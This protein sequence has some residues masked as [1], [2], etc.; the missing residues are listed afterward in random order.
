MLDGA[1]TSPK[2]RRLAVILGVPWPHA[3][4]LAGL[5]WRFTAKHAPT[6]EIGRHDDEE[7]AAAL[8]WPGEA[9]DLVAALV[10]CRLLDPTESAARL[11]VHDWP[12]HAPRYVSATL[13]RQK[14][15]FSAEYR[16]STTVAT[17][18]P[19]VVPTTVETTYTS[20]SSSTSSGCA[21]AAPRTIQEG[22]HTKQSARALVSIQSHE[23]A[24]QGV[25]RVSMDE[26][27]SGPENAG[28]GI[29]RPL[30]TSLE[31]LAE[32]VWEAYLAGRKSGKRSALPIISKSIKARAKRDRCT[33]EEAADR[34][35]HAVEA[36]VRRM[37]ERIRTGETELKYCP[38][39]LTYF[40]Q[41][42][43]NDDDNGPTDHDV[44]EARIDDEIRRARAELG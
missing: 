27:S 3:L 23:D 40:R 5:L 4:G 35:R 29:L 6:G 34:I 17:T 32:N 14:L 13:K 22:G 18:V 10:R 43:W 39:G 31:K 28:E 9:E 20:T 7:I 16:R 30:A 8:E 26:E 21:G 25:P 24:P 1:F 37:I 44:R 36:D 42:R 33:P 19:T 12:E 41:E 11:L 38:M 15:R 2:I